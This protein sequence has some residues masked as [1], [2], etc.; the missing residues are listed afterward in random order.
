MAIA[1]SGLLSAAGLA[2]AGAAAYAAAETLDYDYNTTVSVPN[3]IRDMASLSTADVLA[4]GLDSFAWPLAS[5][6]MLVSSIILAATLVFAPPRVIRWATLVLVIAAA[7]FGV[8][9]IVAAPSV[10]DGEHLR[11]GWVVLNLH[12][13][14]LLFTVGC[15]GFTNRWFRHDENSGVAEQG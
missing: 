1:L 8:L 13:L 9:G 10:F 11:E 6:L 14:W 15:A 3:L 12:S 4:G 7:P 2:W 5:G